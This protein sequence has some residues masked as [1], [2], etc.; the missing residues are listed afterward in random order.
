MRVQVTGSREQELMCVSG[1]ENSFWNYSRKNKMCIHI[2]EI[3]RTKLKSLKIGE[4]RMF[5][6]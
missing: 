3:L 2:L 4:L 1:T 5:L 6:S